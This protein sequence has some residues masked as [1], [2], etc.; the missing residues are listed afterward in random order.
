MPLELAPAGFFAERLAPSENVAETSEAPRTTWERERLESALAGD[1][2]AFAEL[3]EPHL[4]LMYR[5]AARLCQSPALAEDAVQ[6]A[7]TVAYR[8][9]RAYQPGTS[10]KAFLVAIAAGQAETLLRSERRRKRREEENPHAEGEPSPADALEAKDLA[11]RLREA[12]LALPEKRRAVALLRLDGGLSYAEIAEALA[13]TEASARSLAHLAINAL[14]EVLT[15]TE[16]SPGSKG[17][18]S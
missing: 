18:T 2:R 16:A 5:V 9:L 17:H 7:L 8:R 1:G 15:E 11:A 12:L 3:V 13:T 10:L 4:S 14:R 6:D